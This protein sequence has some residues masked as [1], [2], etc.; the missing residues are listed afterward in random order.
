[1]LRHARQQSG[2]VS[3]YLLSDAGYDLHQA[4]VAWWL[5]AS[6]KPK[7]PV[8]ISIPSRAAYLYETIAATTDHTQPN[9]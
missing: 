6:K 5:L 8:D 1:M 2:R 4:P 7:D 9:P 3:L